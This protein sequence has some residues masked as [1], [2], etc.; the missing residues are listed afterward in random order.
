VIINFLKI[1]YMKKLFYVLSMFIMLTFL[2]CDFA[3]AQ[4]RRK[5]HMK[6]STKG[7]IVGGAGGALAGAAISHD[8]SKG[9]I[10]G[11]VAG[12]GAGYLIGH[13]KDKKAAG[14]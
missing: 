8:K 2:T 12:A 13:K 10:I 4:T 6:H 1:K 9:A 5:H 11:G 14:K 3:N 7:A